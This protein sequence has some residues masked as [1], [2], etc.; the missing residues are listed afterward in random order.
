[1]PR[2]TATMDEMMSQL[3]DQDVQLDLLRTNADAE[4]NRIK[5]RLKDDSAELLKESRKLRGRITRKAKTAFEK[6]GTAR[7]ETPFGR[8][9]VTRNPPKLHVQDEQLTLKLL[10]TGGRKD[11]IRTY[12]EPDKERMAGET[13]DELQKYGVERRQS[14]SVRIDIERVEPDEGGSP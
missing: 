3:A 14:V 9:T 12:E 2:K 11:L 7:H 1:M 6:K 8:V 10:H 13:D 5:D 4:I